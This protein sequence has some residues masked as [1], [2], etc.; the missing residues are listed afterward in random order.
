[1][2]VMY[3]DDNHDLLDMFVQEM[4]DRMPEHTCLIFHCPSDA[5]KFLIEDHSL[6]D[7]IVADETM[8]EMN[9]TDFL[10]QVV[11]L[12]YA[13]DF[14]VFSGNCNDTVAFNLLK[15]ELISQNPSLTA[16][17]IE[18]PDFNLLMEAVKQISEAV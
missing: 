3:V 5:L 17:M 2:I 9:G 7:L 8:P 18:K 15:A 12:G 6:V 11:A 10:F 4:A 13:K 16:R 1:M 14:I